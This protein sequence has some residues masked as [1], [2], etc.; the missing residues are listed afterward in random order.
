MAANLHGK[1]LPPFCMYLAV[2]C[3]CWPSHSFLMGGLCHDGR[4]GFSSAGLYQGWSFSS[5]LIPLS[6]PRSISLSLQLPLL[7]SCSSTSGLTLIRGNQVATFASTL[8]IGLLFKPLHDRTKALI[9]RRF[10]RRKYDAARTIATFSAT[11]RD[12]V[13]LN[14]LCSKLVAVVEETIQPAHVSVWLCSP[15][16]YLEETTRALPIIDKEAGL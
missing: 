6:R 8:L 11:I 5:S 15:K 9:D 1:C 7:S 3:L 10:Y 13:D 4:A 12:E 16:R 14:Q 2:E